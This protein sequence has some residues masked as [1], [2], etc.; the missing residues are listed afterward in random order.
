[1]ATQ[2]TGEAVYTDDMPSPVGTLYAGLVLS[3]KPHAKLL[4]VDPSEALKLEG[5]MRYV[6]SRDV[7][8]ERNAIGAILHD[9]EV[10]AVSEV[11]TPL[12]AFH[13]SFCLSF[14][15]HPFI[16]CFVL[17]FLHV[18][19]ELWIPL[20]IFSLRYA[21][22]LSLV[23]SLVNCGSVCFPHLFLFTRFLVFQ[24]SL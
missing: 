9:E 21:C 15:V 1:M 17:F 3:T 6:G 8:P 11:W 7:A 12:C 16:R 14:F 20:V 24:Y 13:F 10:F 23:R 2:V 22:H 4:G 18:F 19:S 5:V